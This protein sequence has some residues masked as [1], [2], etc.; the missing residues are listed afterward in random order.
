[1]GMLN[2]ETFLTSGSDLEA[3]QYNVLHRLKW[4]YNEFS[5]NRLYPAL[6][7]LIELSS[8]LEILQHEKHDLQGRLPKMLKRVDVQNKRLMYEPIKADRTELDRVIEL[9]NWA[10]PHLRAAIEEGMGVYDYVDENIR[11]EQVGILPMY[12]EEGYYFIPEHRASLLHL[13]RYEVTLFTSATERFRSLKLRLLRSLEQAFI[14]P[15]P[16][17][18]KL[19]LI[20]THD[21]L[22]N[23]ATFI[24]ETDLGFP[25]I[26]TIL[27][28]AKRKLLAR[29]FA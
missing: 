26:E 22:P 11:V 18:L 3:S 10:L 12:K 25:F 20:K 5:H 7:E 23:P 9:I 19:E 27:P 29:V 6:S 13:H 15:S 8:T 2:L 4:Y 1:M 16:G 24:C 14:H 28:V 17:S 21:D